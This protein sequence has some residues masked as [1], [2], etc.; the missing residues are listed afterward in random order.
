MKH[1]KTYLTIKVSFIYQIIL[2]WLTPAYVM[3][4]IVI[5]LHS[6]EFILQSGVFGIPHDQELIQLIQIVLK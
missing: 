3:G 4:K 6:I 5:L 1:V 2:V